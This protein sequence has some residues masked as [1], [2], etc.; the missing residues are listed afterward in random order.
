MNEKAS[1]EALY[2]T[3]LCKLL[4]SNR[5]RI[6]TGRGPGTSKIVKAKRVSPAS[7]IKKYHIKR[8]GPMNSQGWN[9]YSFGDQHWIRNVWKRLLKLNPTCI[10]VNS[11]SPMEQG[12][13][14]TTR[15]G[16]AKFSQTQGERPNEQT[17]PEHSFGDQH[18]IRDVRKSL[19]WSSI[20]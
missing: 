13:P 9:S 1:F 11:S 3:H 19:F 5:A 8:R 2:R 10:C 17:R 15:P 14:H 12:N 16:K 20:P 4:N 7:G 6:S 18:W